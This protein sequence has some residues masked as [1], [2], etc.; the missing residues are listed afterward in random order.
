MNY[1]TSMNQKQTASLV[2]DQ[3]PKPRAQHPEVAAD[4]PQKASRRRGRPHGSKTKLLRQGDGRLG[5]HHFAFLR[6]VVDGV[7]P[8]QAWARYL[9]F[10]GDVEDQRHI[11]GLLVQL[12][13][14]IDRA[15]P[16]RERRLEVRYLARS[17]RKSIF[18]AA[19]K[20][21]QKAA[22]ARIPGHLPASEP[23]RADG[24]APVLQPSFEVWRQDHCR[25]SMIDEDFYTEAEWLELYSD[26]CKCSVDQA[27]PGAGNPGHLSEQPPPAL[28]A[29]SHVRLVEERQS[30]YWLHA[31]SPARKAILEALISIEQNAAREPSLD[32]PVDC[33][34]STSTSVSLRSV[35]VTSLRDLVNFV[36]TRGPK[37]HRSVTRIGLVRAARLLE[38]MAPIAKSQ[39]HPMWP[40][41]LRPTAN[42][43]QSLG[44]SDRNASPEKAVAGAVVFDGTLLTSLAG[45]R[46][47]DVS[48]QKPAHAMPS[49]LLAISM[50]LR[51][52]RDQTLRDYTRIAARFFLWCRHVRSKSLATLQEP[53]L[54]AYQVFAAKPP[55]DWIQ[56]SNVSLQDPAWRPFRGP[57]S[58]D[59]LRHEFNVLRSM[60]GSLARAGHLPCNRLAKLPQ[61]V[62]AARPT[63]DAA[64]S[65]SEAHL[66]FARQLLHEKP[67]TS[68]RRRIELLF[69][70]G[71]TTGLRLSEIATAR[72]SG[73]RSELVDGQHAW[74][75]DVTGP[76]GKLRS[77]VV[78]AHVKS[79]IDQHHRDMDEAG[80]GF[81]ESILKLQ[82]P[83]SH[84]QSLQA[85]VSDAEKSTAE[86]SIILPEP[87]SHTDAP[88]QAAVQAWRPLV[89]ILKRPPPQ[90][91]I[92][93]D[94]TPAVDRQQSTQA[95]RYGALERSAIYKLLRRFFVSAAQE[96]EARQDAPSAAEFRKAS[97]HWLRHTFAGK[98]IAQMQPQVL[99]SLLG[100]SHLR[101]TLNY[102]KPD[103]HDM[104]RALLSM[105]NVRDFPR[106]ISDG[107]GTDHPHA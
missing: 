67:D 92:T 24:Q 89:G 95:D 22:G 27:R 50:W 38:W 94:G 48:P 61:S 102:A 77:V 106:P 56:P 35:G 37:W 14:I 91:V 18:A 2:P 71:C 100:H 44:H 57:L 69:E 79:L 62:A 36:N 28:S 93:G 9:A 83:V 43:T 30:A 41:A 45:A 16:N 97:T 54:Q 87:A 53:D 10:S 82:L 13:S 63:L 88:S 4:V 17:L 58:Q 21:S 81:D 104:V 19:T 52:Y 33:W 8:G 20:A 3:T 64:R 31:A 74:L 46:S 60:F 25:K 90:R 6:A 80:V 1:A 15:I 59:S 70:L 98:A 49:D 23:A 5:R 55:S 39:G 99:Q 96:A 85:P 84:R 66:K 86:Q 103:T 76:R 47:P 65:L 73:F 107:Q 78:L 11:N 42:A 101:V 32:D 26:D 75:L 51:R 72:M 12:T 40:K 29:I 68:K 7:D 105:N 34:L